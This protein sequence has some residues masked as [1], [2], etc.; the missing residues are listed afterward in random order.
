LESPRAQTPASAR[1]P[2]ICSRSGPQLPAPISESSRGPTR[3]CCA[4]HE[5]E[6]VTTRYPTRAEECGE[7]STSR[8]AAIARTPKRARG[9]GAFRPQCRWIG[10]VLWAAA[11]SRPHRP[12]PSSKTVCWDDSQ[13][14][15]GDQHFPLGMQSPREHVGWGGT[16]IPA[17]QAPA[18]S[19]DVPR[20]TSL[21]C[22]KQTRRDDRRPRAG[23]VRAVLAGNSLRRR[24]AAA[25]LRAATPR[26]PGSRDELAYRCTALCRS[27]NPS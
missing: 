23:L 8:P 7:P 13:E 20:G 12:G 25:I 4:E 10:H 14:L 21:L 11:L 3:A 15:R 18:E 5:R 19:F 2:H 9:L 1:A 6:I 27:R 16:A 17:G 24:E 26:G 22:P